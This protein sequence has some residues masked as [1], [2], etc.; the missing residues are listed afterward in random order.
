MKILQLSN[1]VPWPL[2]EGGTIGI[3]NFTKAFAEQGHE[4]YLYCLDGL[5]HQTPIAQATAELSKY[6]KLHIH[7]IDTDLK[8]N[9][10]FKSLFKGGSYNVDRFENGS[11]RESLIQL[12]QKEQ[13]DVVQLEGTFVGPYV[14]DVR[15]HHKGLLSLRMHNAEFE[16][17]ARLAD[18]E[19]NPIKKSYLKIL[20]RR[21]RAYES[22][23]IRK[24]DC[25][26]SVSPDDLDKFKGLYPNLQGA[27]FPAGIDSKHWD[28][29]AS[30]QHHKLYHIGSLEWHANKEAVSYFLRDIWPSLKAN[31][32]ELSFHL[33]GKGLDPIAFDQMDIEVYPDVKEARDFVQSKD[34]CVVPLLSGSGI[35]LK[36][37][38]AMSTGKLVISTT[39]GAQGINYEAGKHLLIADRLEEWIEAMNIIRQQ[40][41]LCQ[42]ITREARNRIE[43]QY[44]IEAVSR[45]LIQ[46]YEG[47]RNTSGT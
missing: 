36:I 42:Q 46:Y 44:S 34:I 10:A 20:A 29:Q 17:W 6:A 30:T 1:R 23:L 47:F 19:S 9:E 32:Q 16:I 5:K 38:E 8:W 18:G 2:N 33:A 13:F 26:V 12:L 4:V 21:L 31:N 40:P 45:Q 39:V 3:Y 37:L 24:V 28:Y 25:V 11:F 7:P 35:R 22:E 27:V 43:E 15:Q 14:D 41:E